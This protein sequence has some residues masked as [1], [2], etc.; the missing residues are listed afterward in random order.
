M[1]SPSTRV[2][3]GFKPFNV[4]RVLN[5]LYGR[6]VAFEGNGRHVQRGFFHDAPE[7]VV[8]LGGDLHRLRT[9]A[10]CQPSQQEG[11]AGLSPADVRRT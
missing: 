11:Q 10:G 2:E 4:V 7:V 1:N 5:A 9:F 6:L 8:G 3:P